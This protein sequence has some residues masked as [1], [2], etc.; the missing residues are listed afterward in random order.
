ML[1]KD[2]IHKKK[3]ITRREFIGKSLKVGAG[4]AAASVASKFI[5]SSKYTPYS[6]FAGGGKKLEYTPKAGLAPG[7]IGG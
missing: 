3:G 6:I 7:M 2:G 5:G 4:I 1:E